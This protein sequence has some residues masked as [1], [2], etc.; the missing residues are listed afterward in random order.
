MNYNPY[1]NLPKVPSFEVTS[2]DVR[3]GEKMPLPYGK[4]R[5]LIVQNSLIHVYF[6]EIHRLFFRLFNVIA[7]LDCIFGGRGASSQCRDML[8][9]FSPLLFKSLSHDSQ[10]NC[11][12]CVSFLPVGSSRLR[13]FYSLLLAWKEGRQVLLQAPPLPPL[14]ALMKAK[15]HQE[16]DDSSRRAGFPQIGNCLYQRARFGLLKQ[17]ELQR[18]VRARHEPRRSHFVPRA[19]AV[20]TR[21]VVLSSG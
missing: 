13:S 2:E 11:H 7:G 4:Q 8:L 15:A 12:L 19:L 20:L 9:N 1:E 16:G 5:F 17:T 3:D 21:S 18:G 10:V 6:L 14:I